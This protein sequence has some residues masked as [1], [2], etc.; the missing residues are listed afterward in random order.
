MADI[1]PRLSP[2]PPYH[3]RDH[4][5]H[6]WIPLVANSPVTASMYETTALLRDPQRVTFII[7]ILCSLLDFNILLEPSL[8]NTFE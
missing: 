7:Q 1:Q 6:Q 4:L 3:P 5:L 8:L 2:F